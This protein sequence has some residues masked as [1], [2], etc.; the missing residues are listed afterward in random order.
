LIAIATVASAPACGSSGDERARQA[1]EPTG[2]ETLST[3]QP[4]EFVSKRY[5]FRVTLTKDWSEH[6]AQVDWDGKRLQGMDSPAFTNIEDPA[7][8]RTLVAAAAPV[9]PGTQLRDWQA[10]MVGAA[11]SFCSDSSPMESTLDGD[12]ALAWSAIC[13]D[14]YDVIKLAALHGERGY[15]LF[16]PSK[17]A[18]GDAEDRRIFESIRQSFHFTN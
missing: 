16:L 2:T 4:Q 1:T 10:A 15:M 5:D 12:P 3:A 17:A 14:G 6:D 11:P 8:D 18:N 9:A 13:S 7:T